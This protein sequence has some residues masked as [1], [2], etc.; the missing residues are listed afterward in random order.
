M[1]NSSYVIL[2]FCVNKL[3]K[4]QINYKIKNIKLASVQSGKT[5]SGTH[6][7]THAR[8]HTHNPFNGTLPRTTQVSRYQKGKTNVDFTEARD[9][10]ISWAICKSAPR[11]RQSRQHPTTEVF[12]GRMTF[13]LLN[14]WHK[15]TEGTKLN[16]IHPNKHI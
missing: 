2:G 15:S 12:T 3:T 5:K 4:Y 10:G 7:R 6:T 11:S 9:S 8:T 14:E 16:L 13:L 1:S